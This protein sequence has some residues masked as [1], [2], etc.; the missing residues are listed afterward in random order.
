VADAILDRAI[1]LMPAD[2][3]PVAHGR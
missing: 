1:A 2:P 3:S